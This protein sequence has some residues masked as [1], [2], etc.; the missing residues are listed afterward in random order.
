MSSSM[1]RKIDGAA[2]EA[3]DRLGHLRQ[4]AEA[5]VRDRVAPAVGAAADGVAASAKDAVRSG[6]AQVD[7]LAAQ[8]R[9]QPLAS[10]L[11]AAAVGYLFCR[12]TR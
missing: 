10:V 1:E 2:D 3:V 12:F 7:S 5:L 4:D 8:V 6:R 9:D 11:I